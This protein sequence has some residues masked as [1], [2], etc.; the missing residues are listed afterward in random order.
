MLSSITDKHPHQFS[1]SSLTG[2]CSD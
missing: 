1:S 2:W